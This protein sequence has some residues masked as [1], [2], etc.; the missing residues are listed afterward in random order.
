MRFATKIVRVFIS[1]GNILKG[2][3]LNVIGIALSCI[4]GLILIIGAFVVF[5]FGLPA[6][7]I[8]IVLAVLF[9]V[10]CILLFWVILVLIRIEAAK[11]NHANDED[12]II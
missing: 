12:E 4:L 7:I 6:A 3:F 5:V 9:L 1:L 10:V 2:F 8:L 11:E